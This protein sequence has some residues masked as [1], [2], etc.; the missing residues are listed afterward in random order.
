MSVSGDPSQSRDQTCFS[1]S[2]RQIFT[3]G[4]TWEVQSWCSFKPPGSSEEGR[5]AQGVPPPQDTKSNWE[6][7]S[8][9]HLFAQPCWVTKFPLMQLSPSLE[10]GR[11]ETK[12][13]PEPQSA[14]ES[15]AH[16][17]VLPNWPHYPHLLYPKVLMGE[18]GAHTP[19]S[20][21]LAL[22]PHKPWSRG[23]GSYLYHQT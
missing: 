11:L 16:D 23:G 9:G 8:I 10:H 2:G 6:K 14:L 5:N 13:C 1:C 20:V 17:L 12:L 18:M 3:A 15:K 4:V 7:P 21:A 22:L 19:C